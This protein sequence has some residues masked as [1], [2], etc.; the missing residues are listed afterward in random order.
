MEEASETYEE[1]TDCQVSL[2]EIVWQLECYEISMLLYLSSYI[3]IMLPWRRWYL[4]AIIIALLICGGI[5][6]KDP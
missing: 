6:L 3:T 2:S 1:F 4:F 5:R